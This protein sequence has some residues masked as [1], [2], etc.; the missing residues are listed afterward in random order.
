M[1]KTTP[2]AVALLTPYIW[3]K[4]LKTKFERKVEKFLKS[5]GE[6]INAFVKA[7]DKEYLSRVKAKDYIALPVTIGNYNPWA[8]GPSVD[9]FWVIGTPEKIDD[10]RGLPCGRPIKKTR[11]IYGGDDYRKNPFIFKNE[12]DALV[13]AE[14]LNS[15]ACNVLKKLMAEDNKR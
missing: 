15:A 11:V 4:S 7:F 8:F 13:F 1:T 10:L 14:M 9:Y 2:I 5:P 12:F 6:D 3:R